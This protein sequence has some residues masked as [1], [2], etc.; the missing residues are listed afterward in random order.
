MCVCISCNHWSDQESNEE[1]QTNLIVSH[2]HPRTSSLAMFFFFFPSNYSDASTKI[3]S[4]ER[5][6]NLS[7][8]RCGGS[9]TNAIEA[10]CCRRQ[11]Q[12]THGIWGVPSVPC[13]HRIPQRGDSLLVWPS[14]TTSNCSWA[15]RAALK[16]PCVGKAVGGRFILQGV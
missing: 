7:R 10:R 9:E 11:E 13:S 5:T 14:W 3:S 8:A 16:S 1:S 15:S 2:T 4:W 6:E 12:K